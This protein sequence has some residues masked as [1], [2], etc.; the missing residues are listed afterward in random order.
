[1]G[2]P[3]LSAPAT[4]GPVGIVVPVHDEEDLLPAALD[5][6]TEAANHPRLDGRPVWLAVVLD[7]CTDGSGAAARE[8]AAAFAR[9]GPDRH[10]VVVESPGANVGAARRRGAVVV[11]PQLVRAGAGAWL[12]TTDADSV[13]QPGWLARQL[14]RQSE[15]VEA[16]AGAVAVV[17]W[18]GRPA[19]LAAR[20]RAAYHA[21]AA[22]GHVHG[23]SL[24]V[25]L[26]AY[27]AAG[28]FPPLRT[29]EDRALWAAL[30]RIGA[31][32][33]HD[34]SC[35]VRTSAR[36]APQARAPEGF[37]GYLDALEAAGGARQAASTPEEPPDLLAPTAPAQ[38]AGCSTTLVQPS[39]RLSKWA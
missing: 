31:R 33:V 2:A 24:G 27:R 25:S 13:V 4:S 23:T 19:G 16:W 11:T 35:P 5:A 7:G 15:G 1:M 9:S 17:D 28:G 14:A 37:A 30:G 26:A 36:R 21:G 3:A 20:F 22:T 10:A 34:A 6:L 8:G 18:A 32:R 29:G 38:A 39:S 12:A